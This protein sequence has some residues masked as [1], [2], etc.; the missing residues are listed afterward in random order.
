MKE[1]NLPA[2]KGFN[3]SIWNLRQMIQLIGMIL[4]Y[5]KPLLEEG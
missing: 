4:D 1:L 5:S 3:I 2:L